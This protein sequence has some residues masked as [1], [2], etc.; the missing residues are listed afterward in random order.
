LTQS[1][2]RAEGGVV[3]G[4]A[5]RPG[6][7][8]LLYLIPLIVFLVLAA[9]F[10]IGLGKNPH[11]VPSVLIDTPVPEFDLPP[12]EGRDR[13]LASADLKGQ[14]S[15]VNVFGSW[16]IACRIEHPLLMQLHQ[17]G[18]VPLHGINWREPDAQAGPAWLQRHGDPY[19]LIGADP[20][21]R[22]AIAF[23]VSGAP[24][25]FIVDR[26][27]VI[28]YKQIGPITPDIWTKTLWPIIQ[29]LRAE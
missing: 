19:T 18:V 23:G 2:Q 4:P 15:L 11:E 16:C 21:S 25:T 8:R 13:G 6:L 14:V 20:E 10:F 26:N 12:I 17:S 9:Y 27:G 22:A 29:D 5:K 1:W 24:E 3:S 7:G 28:R